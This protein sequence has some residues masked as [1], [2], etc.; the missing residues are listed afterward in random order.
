M[1]AAKLAKAMGIA[2]AEHGDFHDAVDALRRVG[3][4]VL[5]TGNAVMLPHPPNQITGTFRGNQRG[6]GFVVPDSASAHGDLYIGKGDTLDAVTGDRVLCHVMSRG[7]RDGKDAFGGK[8]L[9]IVERGNSKF[10]GQLRNDGGIWFVQPDG[11]TLHVPIFVDDVGAKGAKEG[12][13]VVVEIVRYPSE[14]QQAKGVIVER[15]GGKGQPGVDLFSIIH[16]YHLP[17]AFPEEVLDDARAVV[18]AF[19]ADAELASREDITELFTITIDPDDAKDFDDAITLT[20]IAERSGTGARSHAR[21]K[22]P[23][24]GRHKTDPA[25]ARGKEMTGDGAAWELGVHIADVSHF[26]REGRPM[27]DEARERG[28][29]VYFPGHVIPMLPEILSNGICSLQE[30]ELRLCKSAFIRYNAQGKVMSARF[31]NTVIKSDKRLTYG[32]ASGILDGHTSGIPKP[33]VETVL[34]MDRL[35]KAIQQRRI[36]D[37]MIVLDLPAVDLVLDEDGRVID[38]QPE[39]RSFSHTII[40]MFMVEANEAV[41]RLMDK[42]GV[43]CIRRIHPDPDEESLEAMARF[44]RAAGFAVP[45]KIT[46]RDLQALLAPLKGKPEGYA[47]N[48]AVLKS[49]QLAEYSP[50]IV[51]HFALASRHYAHFTSPIRRYADLMVHRLLERYFEGPFGGRNKIGLEDVP[52]EDALIDMGRRLSYAS[53]RAE[54]AEQELRTVKVLQLLTEHVGDE[55]EGVVTGVT[56]FGLFVQHPKYLIDGLLRIEDLG[57]DWW[58]A[59]VKAG[60]VFGE[61]TRQVFTMGTILR[62]QIAEVDASARQLNLALVQGGQPVRRRARMAEPERGVGQRGKPRKGGG[63]GHRKGPSPRQKGKGGGRKSRRGRR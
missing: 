61:R 43:P 22:D 37:G 41:A 51:G 56:N 10:V 12:D 57:D 45:K 32:Q 40:E 26:V 27:D 17:Q 25:T 34:E 35:A 50:K 18:K 1:R 58:E 8:I 42:L 30:G 15:L 36:D 55:F 16:Q 62:V 52:D 54:S 20:R 21:V 29:S 2:E 60:R 24:G 46:P 48:L 31:A 6:F 5:G 3:R 9:K 7:K 14:R 49:M 13:Q 38:A 23:R 53:R 39:D 33:V 19:D 44:M 28:T 47:V 11:N 63:A 4:V 59:D